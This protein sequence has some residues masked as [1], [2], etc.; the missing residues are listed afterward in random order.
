MLTWLASNWRALVEIALLSVGIH[1]VITFIRGTRAAAAVTGFLILLLSL[2]L[3]T[4]LLDLQVL[5]LLLLALFPSLA[6]IVI[7]LFQPELRR[8]LARLGN[9]PF[10]VNVREQRESIEVIVQAA[11]RL[12]D[13]RIGMLVAIEQTVPVHD[14][15]ESGIEVDCQ[16][17]PEMLETIFFPNNAIHDGG[18]IIR[19]DRITHAAC[20]FPLSTRPDLSK[21]LGT[22]HRAAIGL[23]EETD[24][25][26]VV[27]S[28]E[29]GAISY[30]HHGRLVRN[31]SLEHLRDFLT[32]MLV[33]APRPR[34]WMEWLR[35]LRVRRATRTPA[36]T[37]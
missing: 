26:V 21:T 12:A 11:E 19:G 24:A 7:V 2:T 17:T 30:A 1:Y 33:K 6:V 31:V 3:L 20:I 18:V 34:S 15:V 4:T 14:V 22:R 28:E 5:K 27:V 13:V 9:L 16:A 25:I 10:F 35:N 23:S 36:P 32:R 29:T 37:P 8:L